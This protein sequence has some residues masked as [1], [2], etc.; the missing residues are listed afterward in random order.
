M[1]VLPYASQLTPSTAAAVLPDCA[2]RLLCVGEWEQLCEFWDCLRGHWSRLAD[3]PTLKGRFMYVDTPQGTVG[4]QNSHDPSEFTMMSCQMLCYVYENWFAQQPTADAEVSYLKDKH[5]PCLITYRELSAVLNNSTSTAQIAFEYLFAPPRPMRNAV[6]SWRLVN[7]A[8]GFIHGLSQNPGRIAL[9]DESDPGLVAS[10]LSN[11]EIEDKWIAAF[12]SHFP[13]IRL[14][15]NALEL[16]C[17]RKKEARKND[18][19]CDRLIAEVQTMRLVCFALYTYPV[20]FTQ[21]FFTPVCLLYDGK[22]MV[23]AARSNNLRILSCLISLLK[24]V[25]C[26]YKFEPLMHLTMTRTQGPLLSAIE[27]KFGLISRRQIRG[28]Y[29]AALKPTSFF[30]NDELFVLD[31]IDEKLMTS[32]STFDPKTYLTREDSSQ[33][34]IERARSSG[35]SSSR[36]LEAADEEERK[37]RPSKCMQSLNWMNDT[38]GCV[39]C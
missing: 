7:G 36:I 13:A 2:P 11:P 14:P 37:L 15:A 3:I 8:N 32:I 27:K 39:V 30:G 38:F 25:R 23:S 17:G 24:D 21:E 18:D 4:P 33:T 22:A 6:G 1:A 34:A 9:F 26:D 10:V 19:R 12:M 29:S 31:N 28:I 35:P 16:L 5:Y 20:V